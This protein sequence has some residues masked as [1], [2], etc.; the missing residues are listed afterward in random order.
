MNLKSKFGLT[1]KKVLRR[2][3]SIFSLTFTLNH[4][5]RLTRLCVSCIHHFVHVDLWVLR[6]LVNF[7]ITEMVISVCKRP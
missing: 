3:P 1:E 2:I 6:I 4:K 5:Y 7:F